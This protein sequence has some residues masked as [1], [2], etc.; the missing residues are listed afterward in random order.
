HRH[1]RRS[2][3]RRSP[4][5]Q[6][7]RQLLPGRRLQRHLGPG[8]RT[9]TDFDKSALAPSLG[10]SPS[11]AIRPERPMLARE[12]DSMYWMARYV[13]RAEH[14]ARILLVNANVLI[15]VGDLAPALQLQQWQSLLTV[16]RLPEMKNVDGD[17]GQRVAQHLT[18]SPENP[19]SILTCLT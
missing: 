13:E 15:D 16:L 6:P 4:P 12:A 2:H 3:P 19:N 5:G 11:R 10:L 1:A 9:M 18:L 17:I 8:R 14:V 7:R